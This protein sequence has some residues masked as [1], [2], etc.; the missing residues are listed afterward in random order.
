M[1]GCTGKLSTNKLEE[2]PISEALQLEAA[3]PA[4]LGFNHDG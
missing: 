1:V 2:V 3:R 4:V